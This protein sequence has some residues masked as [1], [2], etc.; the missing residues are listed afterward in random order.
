[1]DSLINLQRQALRAWCRWELGD[2]SWATS[3]EYVLA[4]PEE[5]IA[6]IAAEE[7]ETDG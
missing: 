3:I 2:P 5:E 7:S 6:R 4:R 1:M